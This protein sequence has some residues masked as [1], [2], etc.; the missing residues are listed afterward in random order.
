MFLTIR[1]LL[2][3]VLLLGALTA[4]ANEALIRKTLESRLQGVK[5]EG[6]V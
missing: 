1:S 4:Q 2:L 3:A 6:V 5:V